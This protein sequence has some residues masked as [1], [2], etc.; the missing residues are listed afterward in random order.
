[1]RIAGKLPRWK[2][3]LVIVQPDIVLPW[4]R[5]QFRWVWRRKSRPRR[6]ARRPLADEVVALVKQMVKENRTRGAERIRGE[7]LM[8]GAQV[9]KSTIQ[10]YI[11]KVRKPGSPKQSWATFLREQAK[12]S[13][14]C[15]F[16]ETYDL[17][18]RTLASWMP[19]P[20]QEVQ[21]GRNRFLARLAWWLE[22]LAPRADVA[23]RA[24]RP[25]LGQWRPARRARCPFLPVEQIGVVPAALLPPCGQIQLE[26]RAAGVDPSALHCGD[27]R[28]VLQRLTDRPP[29]R[30]HL[31]VA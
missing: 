31:L 6:H 18:S 22:P 15:D 12:D 19:P 24:P 23:P 10:K 1:M 7:L 5:G 2:Q 30:R 25:D 28:A 14:A 8:P 17:F 21:E 4:R 3:A 26:R 20:F 9:S 29:Q 16:L 13:S 27:W 11:D